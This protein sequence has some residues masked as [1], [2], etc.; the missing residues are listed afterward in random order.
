MRS[1]LPRIINIKAA[2]PWG[3]PSKRASWFAEHRDPVDRQVLA[4]RAILASGDVPAIETARAS[5]ARAA[6]ERSSL[7]ENRLPVDRLLPRLQ[8]ETTVYDLKWVAGDARV[9]DF[10]CDYGDSQMFISCKTIKHS[11][12]AVQA[13]VKRMRDLLAT[14][15]GQPIQILT[16]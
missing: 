1:T 3:D 12:D 16:L 6:R 5:I 2:A 13:T 4:L 15:T 14:F 7:A 8:M 11:G 10:E 9:A